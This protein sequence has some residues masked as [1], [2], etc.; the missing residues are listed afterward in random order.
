[1]FTSCENE[2]I[3]PAL[4]LDDFGTC[5][6]PITVV[7]SDFNSNTITL[8]WIAAGD[9]ASWTVEYGIE[10][11]AHGAGTTVTTSNTTIVITG[12]NSNNSYDFYVRANCTDV[13]S[14]DWAGPVTV[15]AIQ[16]NPNCPNPNGLTAVRDT[17]SNTNVNLTW[18]A[19][20]T[21]TQWEIQFG[22]SGFTIGSGTIV[23]SNSATATVTGIAAASAYDFYVRA[24]CS[25]TDSSGWIGPVLVASVGGTPTGTVPGLY[26]LTAFNTSVP[27]DLNGDGTSVTNQMNEVTCFNDSFMTINVNNTYVA[28]SKGVDID[29]NG[30]Y[31]CFTDPDD[32]GTWVLNGTQ[33]TMTSSDTTIDP[34][35]FT[36]SGNTL[37]FT[38]PNGTAFTDDNGTVVEITCDL[39]LIYTKQ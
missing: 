20:S 11:F 31:E 12:L 35:V 4:D 33:L 7:A 5:D 17:A 15:D 18:N 32:T 29:F 37:T 28:D 38:V 23:S 19:G 2:P 21:E 24:K 39:T 27:T 10:G 36:V 34:A 16:V 26:K 8:N 1:M 13:N 9:E 3:D 22:L 25:A 14:S 30:D 6:E